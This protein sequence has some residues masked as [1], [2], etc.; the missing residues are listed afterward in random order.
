MQRAMRKALLLAFVLSAIGSFAAWAQPLL[1]LNDDLGEYPL[2]AHIACLEDPAGTLTIHDV[3]SPEYETLFKPDPRPVPNFGY[4]DSVYWVRF[5]VVSHAERQTQWRLKIGAPFMDDIRLLVPDAEKGGV[6]EELSGNLIPIAKQEAHSYLYIF[7]LPVAPDRPRIFY[8]R[9]KT[10]GMM[11]LPLTI[12]SEEAFSVLRQNLSL[13]HGAI[14]GILLIMAAYNLMLYMMLRD[15]SYAFLVFY[16]GSMLLLLFIIDGYPRLLFSPSIHIYLTNHGLMAAYGLTSV[17]NLL[18]VS[19][20]LNTRLHTPR[21]HRCLL[22]LLALCAAVVVSCFFLPAGSTVKPNYLLGQLD[23]A[24][25]FVIGCTLS[26]R[27]PRRPP[28]HPTG[29]RATSLPT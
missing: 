10:Q 21:L 1:I 9:F 4:T 7:K 17:C 13:F 12:Y 25:L 23:I 11:L 22:A 27:R 8:L 2:G 18:F 3:A 19:G 24:L 20:Y 28:R 6:T 26:W 16:I 14:Y 29:P 15:R 5:Q